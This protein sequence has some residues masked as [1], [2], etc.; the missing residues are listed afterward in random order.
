MSDELTA[1]RP[2]STFTVRARR[3]WFRFDLAELWHFRD[4]LFILAGRDLKLRY[5]QTALGVVWVVLV[6]LAAAGIFSF[7]FGE[8][9]GLSSDGTPY[10]VFSY[11][12][13][14]AWNAFQTT[15]NQASQSLL[16]NSHLVSKVYFPRLILPLSSM[17]STLVDFAVASILMG[18]LLVIYGITPTFVILLVP[19][20]MTVALA[21]AVG[22]GL[23]S[24]ALSVRYRDAKY[25]TPVAL[26]LLLYASPVAYAASNVPA[27]FETLYNLNPMTPLL[28]GFRWSVLDTPAPPIWPVMYAVAVTVVV[29]AIGLTFFNRAER[30]FADV[31]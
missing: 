1:A 28:A 31:I 18:V 27:K 7:V 9:A 20:W 6:P 22:L 24:A 10:I 21:F 4:L 16:G 12:G 2:A 14:L 11:A 8:V 23:F 25:V 19:V 17:V 13:L 3:N 29:L 30:K 26:Q 5:R 15:V